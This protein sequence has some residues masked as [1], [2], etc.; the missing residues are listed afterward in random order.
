MSEGPR[1]RRLWIPIVVIGLFA[2]TTTALMAWPD[3]DRGRRAGTMVFMVVPA[4]VLLLT[5]WL[6]FLSGMRW[7]LRIGIFVGIV[8]LVALT[9]RG[10]EFEGDMVPIVHYRWEPRNDLRLEAHRAAQRNAE[11]AAEPIPAPEPQDF[12]EYRNRNRDGVVS[13]TLHPG[14]NTELFLITNWATSPPR[15]IWRQPCGG[16]YAGFAVVGRFAVT[17]EQRR[18]DEAVVCYDTATGAERWVHQ[19]PAH[20]SEPL[21]GDGPRATPTIAD[22]DVY[23]LG[24]KGHLKR[25]NGATGEVKWE[26][27]ILA[28]NKNIAWGMSGSP[29]VYD[30][31]VVVNPGAQS[32]PF[33]G[34]AV[35]AYDRETGKVLWSGGARRAGYSSPQLAT[36]CGVRQV[37][38]LDG[39]GISGYHPEKGGEI[40]GFAWPTY[41]DINVA[42]P[43][44]LD[45]DR[46]FISSG[47]NHGCAMLKLSHEGEKWSVE[48]LWQNRNMRCKFTSPV[49]REG[50]LY[51]MDDGILTCI[52]ARD[53]TRKWKEGR[54]G[55]GQLL[56]AG[57]Y[58]LIGDEAG[59]LVLV[60]ATPEGYREAERITGAL[61]G[62]KNWNHLTFARGCA[63]L[64]NHFEMACYA[65]T[66]SFD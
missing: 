10:V 11:R 51:G 37:L 12:P 59:K 8:A 35:V 32:E 29:L 39:E 45:G 57:D 19:Y 60:K 34:R 24:G 49:L 6:L 23:S 50:Y 55:N 42:Q 13:V 40:W 48:T 44:V 30:R 46:V 26:T 16:G 25:L 2:A 9:I 63:F 52:D 22:G 28:G 5:V 36:L 18:D 38:L 64:R 21:G 66:D 20:F 56:L 33:E 53:G 17:I 62:T 65:L 27:D 4:T 43:L 3:L 47:Y 58:L 41:M 14:F 15:Q 54:F 61:P 7:P 31:F 1:V